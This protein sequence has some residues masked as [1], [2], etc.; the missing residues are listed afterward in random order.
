[1][2]LSILFNFFL[3]LAIINRNSKYIVQI[4]PYS[5]FFQGI[6]KD[7]LTIK[8]LFQPTIVEPQHFR[9]PV[10][11]KKLDGYFY[12]NFGNRQFVKDHDL[13][14]EQKSPEDKC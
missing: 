6:K 11:N 3:I 13:E 1:M 14:G 2:R 12:I 4:L 5:H 10:R 9:D 8:R 7:K